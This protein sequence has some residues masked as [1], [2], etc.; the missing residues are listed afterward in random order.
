MHTPT[1]L[2]HDVAGLLQRILFEKER[3][4]VPVLPPVV[5]GTWGDL[6]LD[7]LWGPLR[8]DGPKLP[9]EPSLCHGANQDAQ[10]RLSR[11]GALRN[12]PAVLELADGRRVVAKLGDTPRI[13]SRVGA[14]PGFTCEFICWHTE[15]GG[16]VARWV[17]RMRG[18][19]FSNGNL[20]VSAG[21]RFTTLNMR[22]DGAYT[23]YLL[24]R[25]T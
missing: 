1:D 23:W 13:G 18:G 8:T 3:F 22:L 20:E 15:G 7:G 6:S 17:G 25:R 9:W 4:D 12:V 11:L 14:E 19:A 21:S 2:P 16:R 5:G 10:A 24:E